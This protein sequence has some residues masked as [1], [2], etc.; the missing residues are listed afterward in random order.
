MKIKI[1]LITL[2]LLLAMNGIASANLIGDSIGG[3]L[4]GLSNLNINT[5]FTSPATVQSGYEFIGH[6]SNWFAGYGWMYWDIYVDVNESSFEV[7]IN[8]PV[9]TFGQDISHSSGI[10]EPDFPILTISVHQ[11]LQ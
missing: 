4:T 3:S 7:R 11:V 2:T 9:Y 5:Q 8:D 6:A 1:G 10:L